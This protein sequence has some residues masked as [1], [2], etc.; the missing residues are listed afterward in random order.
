MWLPE[1]VAARVKN[2]DELGDAMD[3]FAG[4]QDVKYKMGAIG[5]LT[6]GLTNRQEAY[7]FIVKLAL[8]RFLWEEKT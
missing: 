4:I 8:A 6:K 1:S 3:A 2:G 7:E 5:V